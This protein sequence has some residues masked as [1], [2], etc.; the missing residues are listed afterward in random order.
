ML[1]FEDILEKVEGYHPKVD[2]ALLRRAYVVSAHAHRNQLRSSG[3]PYLVHPLNVAMILADMRLD[4]VSI[5]TGLLHDVLEDTEMTKERLAELFG[6]DVAHLVDGV[7]K[8]SRYA[9]TSR[10]AQQAETFRK[11]LLAMTDDLR[12]ILVKL[13]DRLH[14]MRTLEHLPEEKRRAIS[15]E[16]MEIYAPLANR[17]GMGKVKGELEDLSFRFLHPDEHVQLTAAIDERLKTSAANVERIRRD[18]LEKMAAAGIEADVT[19]RVKRYWSIRQKLRRQQIPLDQLY[20]I[21]AFR[22]LVDTIPQCYSVLG[23]VHQAWRPVPGRIKDYIAMPKPNFYQ[24]LH[25]TLVPEN[26]PPFEVQIRT[27]EMDLIAENGIA[28]HWKYKEGKLDPRADEASIGMV[29]Q[30][31]E[32]TKEISDPREFLTALRIDLFPDEVYTFSPRGAVF[33]FPR[34]ATPVDFAYRIH[35]DVGHRCVGARVNGRLVPLKTPLENGDIVEVLTSPAAQPSRDWLGFAVTSRAKNKIRA[36]IH[37]AEK[38]K[39]IEI[40]RRLL[41]RELKKFRKSLP[42]LLE[43]KAFD[44]HLGDFGASKVDDLLADIGYG[45]IAP[46]AVVAKLLPPEAAPAEA[47]P[48]PSRVSTLRSAVRRVLPFGPAT[49]IRVKGENDLLATLAECCRPVPGDDIV[50]YVTRGRGVSVHATACPNVRNLLFDPAREIEVEWHSAKD[51]SFTVDLEIRTEDRPGMLA[52]ITQVISAAGSNIRAIEA[53]T[54][55]D[56]TAAIEGSVTTRDR[57]HLEK[58]LV[59][60]RAVP[61]VTEVRRRYNLTGV[62]AG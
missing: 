45:K 4:E 55:R 1:R 53:R 58:L 22:V 60:L 46:K 38:E 36:F 61:G 43:K 3:E 50:G 14:N 23:I 24:A 21:L 57:R 54:S 6:P 42:R 9:F 39:S 12:V 11:M 51:S 52:K 5:A 32:T 44:P 31:L 49:G 16:T 62:E 37:A 41:E 48:A 56:G 17:L 26:A 30:L 20:D 28:A 35:T 15:A 59:T 27:R 19:G 33:S 34:G 2:E 29:R 40:G 10:E 18:L 13:A 8:I 7:T 25:T 47:P